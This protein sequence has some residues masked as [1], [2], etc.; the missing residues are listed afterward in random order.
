MDADLAALN[1]K[2]DER[3]DVREDGREEQVEAIEHE[4]AEE[5]IPE[6][7]C[8]VIRYLKDFER[9]EG[10]TRKKYLQFQCFATKFLLCKEWML[11]RQAKPN[12]PPKRVI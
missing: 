6:E 7:F 4:E 2:D 9:P 3:N 11:F 10:L 1:G 8:K 5:D 12:I